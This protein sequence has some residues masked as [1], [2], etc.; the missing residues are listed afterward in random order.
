VPS[1]AVQV[2]Q[3]GSLWN[4]YRQ[5]IQARHASAALGHGTLELLATG[6]GVL[7]FLRREGA[8]RVL[9]VHNLS[10][11][12]QVATVLVKAEA[13]EALFQD[14]GVVLASADLSSAVSLPPLATGIFRLQP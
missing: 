10:A 1:L 12:A 4:R 9:V 6:S 3:R 5:L 13:A 8:E 7:A 14:P 11:S 2:K